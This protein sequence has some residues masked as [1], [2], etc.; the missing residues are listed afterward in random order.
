MKHA[1]GQNKLFQNA[2]LL[3]HFCSFATGYFPTLNNYM[4]AHKDKV[5][6]ISYRNAA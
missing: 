4:K 5:C 3:M 1:P 6:K 2:L